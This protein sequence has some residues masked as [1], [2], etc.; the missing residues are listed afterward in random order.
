MAD[1]AARDRADRAADA[2]RSW[3][4]DVPREAALSAAVLASAVAE[5]RPAAETLTF[6]EDAETAIARARDID[7]DLRI[8][9]EIEMAKLSHAAGDADLAA[10][11]RTALLTQIDAL[12]KHDQY[13]L[14]AKLAEV[15][16]EA[17]D[18][19][20]VDAAIARANDDA[21]FARAPMLL[22]EV[23][24]AVAQRDFIAASKPLFTTAA[25]PGH[26]G[27]ATVVAGYRAA[28]AP[29]VAVEHA[30]LQRICPR[31]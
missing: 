14:R 7:P 2:R 10:R 24:R 15:A 13:G 28:A 17:G 27:Y 23:R 31:Y 8:G 12:G 21:T 11:R 16:L 5:S 25:S 20:A 4:D 26:I 30:L 19:A 29:D 6:I 3:V 1:R 18:A 9:F 22:V